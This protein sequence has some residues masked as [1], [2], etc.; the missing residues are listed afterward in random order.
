MAEHLAS[1]FG[2]EKD[3]VNCP[4]Y[5]M[6]GHFEDFYE[7]LFEELSKYGELE[8]LN[9]CDNLA[10]H[11]LCIAVPCHIFKFWAFI[12]IMFQVPLVVIT[13]YVHDKFR[14]SMVGNIIFWCFFSIYGQPMCVLLYYHDVKCTGSAKVLQN[15]FYISPTTTYQEVPERTKESAGGPWQFVGLMPLFDPPRHDAPGDGVNDAPALKKADIG[16]VVADATDAARSASD[17]V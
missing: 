6:I 7:D 12:G 4:F 13:K 16:I 5:F 11:M 8:S 9:I 3:R 17:I 10:D 2:T 1:I 14:N 15:R